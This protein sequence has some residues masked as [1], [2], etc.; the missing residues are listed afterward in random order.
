M[1]TISKCLPSGF[2]LDSPHS[3]WNRL[4]DV[5][6]LIFELRLRGSALL[7]PVGLSFSFPISHL[8]KHCA[9]LQF[10]L[11]LESDP[12][13]RNHESMRW[14]M[15][16]LLPPNG[17]ADT[18]VLVLPGGAVV[19]RGMVDCCRSAS[20]LSAQIRPLQTRFS[21]YKEVT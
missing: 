3:P 15:T 2:G 12:Y 6:P 19:R 21:S 16:V 10:L 20:P 8:A 9:Y 11:G 1:T 7:S 18:F 17:S 5:P 14:C 13:V 4:S